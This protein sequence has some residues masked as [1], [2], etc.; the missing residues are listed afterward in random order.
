M[1]GGERLVALLDVRHLSVDFQTSGHTIQ[2]LQ[3][4]LFQV[5]R[6][7]TVCI[8][9]ES[10]SGKSVTSLAL[11]RLLEYENGKISHGEILF[12][13]RDLA[14]KS[15]EEMRHIRGGDMSI[16]FQ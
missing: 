4:I 13:G 11:M 8:V 9:G 2:A 3:D 12:D 16:I 10:G 1:K 5:E 6:G 14:Q 15:Q 7:E